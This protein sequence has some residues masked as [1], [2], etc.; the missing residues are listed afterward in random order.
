[1]LHRECGEIGIRY[2]DE[3]SVSFDVYRGYFE[4]PP[5]F[6]RGNGITLKL[7]EKQDDPCFNLTYGIKIQQH[8][9]TEKH[10]NLSEMGTQAKSGR[11]PRKTR[12]S[13]YAPSPREE[14]NGTTSI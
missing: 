1:M 11:V 13:K 14:A 9:S 12:R 3:N 7:M 2:A 6:I 5:H 10:A 8:D 4:E